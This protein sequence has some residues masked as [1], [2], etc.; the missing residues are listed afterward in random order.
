MEKHLIKQ[1]LLEQ[2]EEINRIFQEKII[3]REIEETVSDLFASYLIKVIMGVR[4][5]G[6]SVL[7]HRLLKDKKYGYVNFDDERLI[8][9]K[10]QDL[11]NFLEILNE[12]EPEVN[13][14]LFDEIQNVEGWELFINRL[15]RKG[16]N[17]VISGSNA[18]LLSK[19][20]ATHL[21]GRHFKIE[22]FPFSFREFLIYKGFSVKEKDFYI[23]EKR[24]QIKRLLEEYLKFGGFPEALKLEPK[25]Q[26]LRE[27]YDKIITRDIILRYNIRYA[28]DLKEIALYA[29]SNFA[30]RISYHKIK[31]IFE[32]KSVHTVKNY[33]AYLEEAYLLFQ[34]SPFSFKLKRQ[35]KQPKK[36]YGID[37]GLI[38]ALVPKIMQN[39]GR[40]MENLVCLELKR[41]DKEVYFYS[42]PNY[43]VD[44]LIK[45]G[46]EIKQ[47][48]QVCYSLKDEKTKKREIKTLLKASKE[49]KCDHLLIITWDE[50]G[51]ENVNAQKIKIYPLWK[52]LLTVFSF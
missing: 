24:A 45:E 6:K 28:R 40:L 37:T 39:Y 31:N 48:I 1:I 42:Q 35:F 50:E 46:F 34:I 10:P 38:N 9:T 36:I 7:A 13:Y 17:I 11:N 15:R 4:R 12:I 41:Q 18:K 27:L 2:R 52:W 19:E 43:E 47:L 23:T 26:Y 30:S 16:Y 5:C 8:G 21:T 3:K 25:S 20:L 49:L 32:I 14:L 22:L 33:L 51:E 44:F 29:I